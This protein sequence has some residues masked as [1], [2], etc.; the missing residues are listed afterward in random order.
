MPNTKQPK[1]PGRPPV[2]AP[3]KREQC[4]FRLSRWLREW[5]ESQPDGNGELIE[6]ALI[7]QYKLKPPKV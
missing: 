5:L 1:P 7:A 3:L 6:A 4:N 2:P